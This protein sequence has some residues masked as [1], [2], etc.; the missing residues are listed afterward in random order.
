MLAPAELR[1]MQRPDNP[2]KTAHVREGV[3]QKGPLYF[4][5]ML[6]VFRV[7]IRGRPRAVSRGS[8]TSCDNYGGNGVPPG[9]IPGGNYSLLLRAFPRIIA[10]QVEVVELHRGSHPRKGKATVDQCSALMSHSG[11]EVWGV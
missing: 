2:R 5:T 3:V 6:N 11:G 9:L 4:S 1:N 8:V 10:V 7:E